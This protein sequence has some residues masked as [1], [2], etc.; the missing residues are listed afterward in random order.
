MGSSPSICSHSSPSADRIQSFE[1]DVHRDEQTAAAGTGQRR[2]CNRLGRP[3]HADSRRAAAAKFDVS[4]ASAVRWHQ[5][6]KRTGSVEPDAVGGDRHSHSRS[7]S[8][9]RTHGHLYCALDPNIDGSDLRLRSATARGVPPRDRADRAA[10][11]LATRMAIPFR[12]ASGAL[13][14]AGRERRGRLARR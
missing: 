9:R 7:R 4:V 10:A 6:Y 11:S 3:S 5:R 13:A 14:R 8:Q 2:S 12:T 1:S